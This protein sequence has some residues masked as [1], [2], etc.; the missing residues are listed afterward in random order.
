[1]KSV[2]ISSR[3]SWVE[4]KGSAS[5]PKARR[6]PVTVFLVLVVLLLRRWMVVMVMGRS[7]LTLVVVELLALLAQTHTRFCHV[8][9][10]A[11]ADRA[12]RIVWSVDS[13]AR[14]NVQSM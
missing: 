7:W 12:A 6:K 2:R 13:C 14:L 11:C 3:M 5:S 4:G 9:G 10:L 8:D 1:M